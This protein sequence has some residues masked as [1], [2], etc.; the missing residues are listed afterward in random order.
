M[1]VLAIPDTG[2]MRKEEP[3]G[4]HSRYE[5]LSISPH[6][7]PVTPRSASLLSLEH[8]LSVMSVPRDTL[9]SQ[10]LQVLRK[11]PAMTDKPNVIFK[12]YGP[13][14]KSQVSRWLETKLDKCKGAQTSCQVAQV[15]TVIKAREKLDSRGLCSLQGTR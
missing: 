6:Q 8:P 13:M 3:R 10:S 15:A 12:A 9:G 7:T 1:T 4:E 5:M 2:L 11:I 14:G